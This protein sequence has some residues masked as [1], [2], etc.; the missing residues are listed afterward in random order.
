NDQ[1]TLV[2]N[3]KR[4][5]TVPVDV[6][7]RIVSELTVSPQ[8]LLMGVVS[9]GDK[10]TKQVVVKGAKP[11]RILDIVCDDDGFSFAPSTE[12]KTVHLVPVTYVA[13]G[14]PGKASIKIRV[15]TD[16]NDA[17]AEFSAHVQVAEVASK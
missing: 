14:E 4:S 2:T 7:G 3:D 6:S 15:V 17:V 5:S 1:L 11:F 13:N 8:S 16:L 10:V 9:N 12:A